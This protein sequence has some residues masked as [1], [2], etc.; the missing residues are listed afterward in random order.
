MTAS[1]EL[2]PAFQTNSPRSGQALDQVQATAVSEITERVRRARQAQESWAELTQEERLRLLK[3]AARRL[4]NNRSEAIEIVMAEVGKA[5]ADALFTEGL[6]PWDTLQ[7]WAKV[8]EKA[9]LGAVG[10]N[11]LA[12]PKKKAKIRLVPRGVVGVIAP[13]NFPIAGL[14]RSVFPALLLGNAVVVKPS[15]LS[16]RSSA[17][18][19]ETLAR[20]LPAGII[21]CVQGG[22]E[23]GAALIEADVDACVFT[24]SSAVG[25]QV[26]K[27]C[28]ERGIFVS[29]EMG[30]KDA[31]I[32]LADADLPRTV[33][34]L[35]QWALQNAGQACG[36]VEI[37]YAE[38][39]IAEELTDRLADAFQRLGASQPL[40]QSQSLSPVIHERQ[41]RKIEAQIQDAL[42]RGASLRAGGPAEGLWLPPTLLS[43]CT[44]EMQVV[45]EETFGPVLAIVTVD[46][47]A[48]AIRRIHRSRYGLT[49]SIWSRDLTRAERLAEQLQ[50]GVVTVNNHAFTGAIA[51]L[52]WSGRRDSGSGIANSAWSLLTFAR[53]QAVV[54]DHSSDA[55]PFWLPYDEDLVQLGNLL[56][57]A[58]VGKLTQAYRIPFLLRR[59]LAQVRAFFG[60]R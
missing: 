42:D 6:G 3:K 48:D 18:F 44:E 38:E 45:Q 24:G 4:L 21:Q 36:A 16:P 35:T 34:G 15:E 25:H 19:V 1:T 39:R 31:A 33:A 53:P 32:V 10:L 5:A 20:E 17:W 26:E 14:Y 57:D 50:V 27:R 54:V 29:A 30:G 8:V 59:R 55:E 60:M 11:P 58:Q 56:A 7:A 52:P 22:A 13:W 49:T 40:S 41:L 28:Q 12:F 43:S 23:V 51:A 46:G 9:P 2:S 47:P 37:V